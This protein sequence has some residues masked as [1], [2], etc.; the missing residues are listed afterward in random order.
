MSRILV[1]DDEI[2]LQE[3][4]AD[5]LPMVGHE[6]V[7]TAFNGEEAVLKFETMDPPPDLIIM[8]HR[9]PIKNGV[10]ATREILGIDPRARV[11]F[12]SA[13]I[14]QESA[15]RKMGAAGFLEK[16]FPMDRLFKTI[17]RVLEERGELGAP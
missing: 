12:I 11:L 5:L 14:S 13:D 17:S 7:E 1:V 8:D 9:M 16:P 2:Y 10:E 6:V 4:Y 3:L 15:V